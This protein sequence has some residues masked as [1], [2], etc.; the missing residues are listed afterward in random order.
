MLRGVWEVTV[1]EFRGWHMLEGVQFRTRPVLALRRV[2]PSP[3]HR[4][5]KCASDRGDLGQR[6]SGPQKPNNSPGKLMM[7]KNEIK[8]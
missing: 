2:E 6:Q 3:A 8:W 1:P 7:M 4:E 5:P